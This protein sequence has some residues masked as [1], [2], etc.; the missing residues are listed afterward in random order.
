MRHHY[1]VL[2]KAPI[3]GTTLVNVYFGYGMDKQGTVT[4]QESVAGS[5]ALDGI[6]QWKLGK[7]VEIAEQLAA[8]GE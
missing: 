8:G 6:I 5:D 4:V 2:S 3:E 7:L 1:V